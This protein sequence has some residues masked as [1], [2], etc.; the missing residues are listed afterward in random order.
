MADPDRGDVWLVDVG[1]VGQ[2]AAVF[3]IPCSNR[4]RGLVTLVPHTT[5]THDS[6]FEVKISSPSFQTGDVTPSI[7]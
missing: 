4:Y 5:G 1:L 2:P 6:C 7:P 3:S